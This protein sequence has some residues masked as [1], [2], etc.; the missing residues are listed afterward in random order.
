M[1]RADEVFALLQEL[2]PDAVGSLA[3]LRRKVTETHNAEKRYDEA[4][5]V[6]RGGDDAAPI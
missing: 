2:A 4:V 6:G 1:E 3:E 5:A